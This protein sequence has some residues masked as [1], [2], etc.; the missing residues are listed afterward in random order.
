MGTRRT[1]GFEES[2]I[3]QAWGYASNNKEPSVSNSCS[4]RERHCSLLWLRQG[5]AEKN[6]LWQVKGRWDHRELR[7][8][9]QSWVWLALLQRPAQ[10]WAAVGFVGKQHVTA[11]TEQDSNHSDKDR[12]TKNSPCFQLFSLKKK[13]KKGSKQTK[14]PTSSYFP[15]QQTDMI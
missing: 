9:E 7:L 1:L 15:Q 12:A 8:H 5:L 13:K 4:V 10:H 11:H 6:S 2:T 14:N 3:G